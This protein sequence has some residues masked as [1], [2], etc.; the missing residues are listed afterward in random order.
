MRRSAQPLLQLLVAAC[1]LLATAAA[2]GLDALKERVLAALHGQNAPPGR[3]W[4]L[5][6]RPAPGAVVQIGGV[7]PARQHTCPLCRQPLVKVP[8]WKG[9]PGID[10]QDILTAH[11]CEQHN[12][13]FVTNDGPMHGSE[14]GPF[15]LPGPGVKP[16]RPFL[17]Y[18][19]LVVDA[20]EPWPVPRWASADGTLVQADGENGRFEVRTSERTV[21]REA[22]A[23][24]SG[25]GLVAW[26]IAGDAGLVAYARS[27]GSLIVGELGTGKQRARIRLPNDNVSSIAI[28][29]DGTHVAFVVVEG[30]LQE[31]SFR[32][33]ELATGKVREFARAPAAVPHYFT[34]LP[35]QGRL[36]ASTH[37][38]IV[39]AWTIATGKQEWQATVDP[40]IN[41]WRVFSRSPDGKRVLCLT[42]GGLLASLLDTATGACE[43]RLTVQKPQP[44]ERNG[45]E[46]SV[47]WSA[48]SRQ[49]AWASPDGHLA[50]SDIAT[51]GDLHRHFG[52]W[53]VPTLRLRFAGD[54][55]SVLSRDAKGHCLCWPLASFDAPE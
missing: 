24:V 41:S 9:K 19:A 18:G 46:C 52:A 55:K 23:D 14:A 37:D 5:T 16:P 3:L 13:F 10:S 32:L 40:G 1:W 4:I 31:P 50:R 20:P 2:Q 38:G 48:D 43:A 54:G 34:F 6:P 25:M 21:Y 8:L 27:V 45:G 15:A 17:P 53:D 30:G 44:H 51:P 47:A 29:P 28:H 26:D 12:L 42:R 33:L 22:K 11:V 39:S 36:L 7:P 49:F 35:G